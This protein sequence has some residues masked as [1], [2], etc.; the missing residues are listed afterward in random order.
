MVTFDDW[1]P[2]WG[3]VEYKKNVVSFFTP[4]AVSV[5]PNYQALE[6]AVNDIPQ[7]VARKPQPPKTQKD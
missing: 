5:Y 7:H 3:P 4:K 6:E 2:H 1:S